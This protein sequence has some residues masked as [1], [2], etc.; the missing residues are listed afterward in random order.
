M[1]LDF[2]QCSYLLTHVTNVDLCESRCEEQIT[3]CQ[4][5]VSSL[6]LPIQLC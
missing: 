4:Q 6:M 3:M 5:E 1:N 2:E